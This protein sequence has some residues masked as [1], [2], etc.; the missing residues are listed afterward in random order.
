MFFLLLDFKFR[1]DHHHARAGQHHFLP[2]RVVKNAFA[3]LI[4]FRTIIS[5]W[6]QLTVIKKA[7]TTA[8][9]TFFY[10]VARRAA[11]SSNTK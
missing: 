10:E 1:K 8:T 7:T 6:R 11:L 5:Q 3:R 9:A 2:R 4:T